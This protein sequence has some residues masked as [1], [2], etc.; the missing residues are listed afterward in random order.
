MGFLTAWR[1]PGSSCLWDGRGLCVR[2][3]TPTVEAIHPFQ[4]SSTCA[5]HHASVHSQPK[6]SPALLDSGVGD[7]ETPS[8]TE[9]VPRCAQ[10]GSNTAWWFHG[11]PSWRR[12]CRRIGRC[13]VI[14]VRYEGLGFQMAAVET[15]KKNAC[16]KASERLSRFLAAADTRFLALANCW[17][18]NTPTVTISGYAPCLHWVWPLKQQESNSEAE[19]A[20]SPRHPSPQILPCSRVP[21]GSHLGFTGGIS[22]PVQ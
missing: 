21:V 17:G 3:P 7:A 13:A 2:A 19:S 11:A 16:G 20:P 6:L 8:Q 14:W 9:G 12:G 1:P 18:V 5:Q 10:A 22:R 15:V 4:S